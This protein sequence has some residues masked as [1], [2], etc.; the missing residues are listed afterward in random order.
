MSENPNEQAPNTGT[1]PG[2]QSGEAKTE[3]T[4]TQ[5]D[6]D[7]IVKERL[8]KQEASQLKQLGV[9]SF[10]EA[11]AAAAK[12]REIEEAQK[13]EAQK[14]QDQLR[15]I[16]ARATHAESKRR[17][18]LVKAEAVV[19]FGKAG[20]ASDRYGAALKLL[21]ASQIK[22]NDDD[23]ISGIEDAI[24]ALLEENAFLKAEPAAQTTPP[25]QPTRLGAT[26]PSG[27]EVNGDV[28]SWHPL[29]RHSAGGGFTGQVVNP[30][31]K[32]K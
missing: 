23:S 11:K 17:E 27:G 1:E 3:R 18:A 9:A 30:P 7:R 5:A 14:L 21:D 26:N 15:A 4:F 10:D 6:L 20:I 25:K 8:V 12:V 22:V 32:G 31:Q 28:R 13:S 19:Q 29:T 16:E 2:Q 24:T